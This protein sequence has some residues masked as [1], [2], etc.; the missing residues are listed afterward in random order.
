MSTKW[1]PNWNSEKKL[2]ISSQRF[3]DR[4]WSRQLFLIHFKYIHYDECFF[5][6]VYQNGYIEIFNGLAN[7]TL[8]STEFT[9]RSIPFGEKNPFTP[10]TS[11]ENL[12]ISWQTTT[13][14]AERTWLETG[15]RPRYAI[16]E[17]IDWTIFEQPTRRLRAIVNNVQRPDMG[18]IV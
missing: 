12:Q 1:Q 16:C 13:G 15:L 8:L 4:Y 14:F 7:A 2:K 10:R 11:G 5:Q 18:R 3:W 17:N 9:F 6:S